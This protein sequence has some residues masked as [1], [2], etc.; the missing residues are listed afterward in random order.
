MLSTVFVWRC[1]EA[2]NEDPR[3]F[4]Q[5]LLHKTFYFSACLNAILRRWAVVNQEK[6]ERGSI[7]SESCLY[8]FESLFAIVALN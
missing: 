4:W 1:C 8:Q 2:A 3:L 6:L 7:S 5:I